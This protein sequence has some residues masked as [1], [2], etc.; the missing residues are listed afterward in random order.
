[1]PYVSR[2]GLDPEVAIVS[3]K[4]GRGRSAHLFIDKKRKFRFDYDDGSKGEWGS[5]VER[6]GA[7]IEIRSTISSACRD[8]IIP[9]FAEAMRQTSLDL[10]KWNGGRFKLATSPLFK[11]DAPSLK[12][13]PEDVLEFGCRPDVDAY[14]LEVKDPSIPEGDRRRYTGG[15]IHASRAGAAKNIEEQAS[16]A[17]LFD[18]FIA[19]P[20]VAILGDKFEKGEAERRQ[21]YGQPGS[22]RYDDRLDKIEFR[23][24]SGRLQLHPI[25]MGW[26]L[27]A[28]KSMISGMQRENGPYKEFLKS[29]SSSVAPELVYDI[30]MN[31]DY[32]A[33]EVISQ[34][35]WQL[36][37]TY[38]VES[39][40]LYNKL[41]GGGGSTSNPYFFERALQVFIEGRKEGLLWDDDL[42][43]N[44][45]LYKDYEP[46][47][48]SY[49]GVHSAMARNCDDDIFPMN[50]LL[51][52]MWEVNALQKV[53]I[54]THPLNGG[55]KEYVHPHAAHWLS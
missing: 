3:K 9:Y 1:M 34:S 43:H 10:E 20:M 15:H 45:G 19:L 25:L 49:W 28:V 30:I 48:H 55:D 29:I 47:H 32:K 12:N 4:S 37:P 17:I 40:A 11:L 2:L 44:W 53:P 5:E 8:N 31:H 46:H 50:K 39:K 16:L 38:R 27:G 36:L 42:I 13:P 52:K 18:Y 26:I 23:T 21:F 35:I 54:F 7:A 33:A 14:I 22:F 24:L 6:D 41:G 51:P